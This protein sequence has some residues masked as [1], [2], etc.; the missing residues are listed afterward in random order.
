MTVKKFYS[1]VNFNLLPECF[2]LVNEFMMDITYMKKGFWIVILSSI[3]MI[4]CNKDN[5]KS[6]DNPPCPSIVVEISGDSSVVAGDSL[7][8]SATPINGAI[9]SWTGPANFTS[10]Q[11]TIAIAEATSFREGIYVVTATISGICS[12]VPDSFYVAIECTPPDS[13]LAN[14]L[15]PVMAGQPL[16]LFAGTI[17]DSVDFVWTGPAGFTSTLQNP[18]VPVAAM[19][20]E[21]T[22][23]V[24]AVKDF[25]YSNVATVQVSLNQCNPSNRT[26]LTSQGS[27]SFFYSFGSANVY[28]GTRSLSG[29]SYDGSKR[30]SV[31]FPSLSPVLQNY[32]VNSAHC[33]SVGGTLAAN[34]CCIEFSDTTVTFLGVSG[35]VSLTAADAMNFCS[36]PFKIKFTNN[37]LFTGAGKLDY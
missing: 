36:V 14:F 16:K 5:D 24:Y 30:L 9:Y 10:S 29:V 26:F 21:G 19:A 17:T 11:R 34:E 13:L 35:S 37:T 12:T 1:K 32:T 25:C 22:Y 20:S 3:C 6:A 28:P 2:S 33:P 7:F 18:I 23:T 8:L 15:S 27:N 31:T 4:A